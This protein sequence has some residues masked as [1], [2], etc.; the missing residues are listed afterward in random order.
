MP[1]LQQHSDR[2]LAGMIRQGNP[3]AFE[4]LFHRYHAPLVRYLQQRTA[5]PDDARDLAQEVFIRVWRRRQFLQPDRALAAYLYRIA[6]NLLVDYQRRQTAQARLMA[7]YREVAET[8][9]PPR[10][11]EMDLQQELNAALGMLPQPW[12]TVFLLSRE[13]GL[14]NREIAE[15]LGISVKTVENRMTRALKSL[16]RHWMMRFWQ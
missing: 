10:D 1:R 13:N 8:T 14:K 6:A 16:R 9:T 4:A 5:D 7:R 12:Q 15:L 2:A 3:A 11:E